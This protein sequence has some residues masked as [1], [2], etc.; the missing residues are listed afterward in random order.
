[1][2]WRGF[3][4]VSQGSMVGSLLFS[5]CT[6]SLNEVISSYGFSI[7]CYVYSSIL[8]LSFPPSDFYMELSS[9]WMTAH[10]LK[11]LVMRH[12]CQELVI[13]LDSSQ[14]SPSVTACNLSVT[15]DNQLSVSPHITKLTCSCK[16]I[17]LNIK[18]FHLFHSTEANQVLSQ[19][20][21]ISLTC[22]YRHTRPP[23]MIQIAAE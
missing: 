3:T 11:V 17:L 14:I 9:S 18:M 22:L 16:F 15:M 19:S 4:G 7:Y 13:F 21:V 12:P 10:K 20:L 8:N 23:R 2:T 5:L 1:M 6:C